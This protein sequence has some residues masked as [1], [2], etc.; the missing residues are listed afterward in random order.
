LKQDIA[1][2]VSLVCFKFIFHVMLMY[3]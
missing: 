3:A 1:L 2:H